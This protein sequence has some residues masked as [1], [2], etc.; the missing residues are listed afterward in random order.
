MAAPVPAA[1]T[2]D[3]VEF[4]R[5]YAEDPRAYR[6]RVRR[7]VWLG[8]GYV[9]A[10]L[11]VILGFLGGG[12]AIFAS[13]ALR[14]TLL[15]EFLRIGV[16]AIAIAGLM[17][18]AVFVR[19]PRP[20]GHYLEGDLKRAVLDF[21]E[22]IRAAT[23]GCRI[24]D[25]VIVSDLN[26]AVQQRPRWGLLGPSTNYLIIGAP[27]FQ[28]MTAEELKAVIAHEFGHLSHAHGRMG[29]TVY[30]LD[31][32][33]RHAASAIEEKAKP[34]IAA[35]TFKFF[36]WFQPRFD[37]VTFAMRRGQE[38]EADSVAAGATSARAIGASLCRLHAVGD[39]WG[40]YW[41]RIWSGSRGEEDNA[42]IR[43]W[44]RLSGEFPDV[45]DPESGA[46]SIQ[47]ALEREA[48]YDDTHPCLRD[49]LAALEVE[50]SPPSLPSSR[51]LD[52]IF[53]PA[54]REALLDRLDAIWCDGSRENWRESHRAYREAEDRLASLSSQRASLDEPGLLQLASLEE[55]LVDADAARSTLAELVERFPESAEARFHQGRLLFEGDFPASERAFV[56]CVERDLE[57][58]PDALRYV[59]HRYEQDGRE[60]D[61]SP[62]HPFV[63][64][65]Q[66]RVERANEE[67]ESVNA[68]DTFV[69]AHLSDEERE[70]LVERLARYPEI[71]ALDLV[72]KEAEQFR[73]HRMFVLGLSVNKLHDNVEVKE[74]KWLDRVSPSISEVLPDPH[75]YFPLFVEKRSPWIATFSGVEGARVYERSVSGM[76]RTWETAKTVYSI[77]FLLLF[78][79]LLGFLAWSW[80]R[81]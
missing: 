73:E 65:Y 51:A 25:V 77:V 37:T 17:V 52:E 20:E 56:A 12:V 57:W 15:D 69:A 53:A 47:A 46:A 34:G 67:R 14:L 68:D 48:T 11:V 44:H 43:P 64:R 9:G 24:D 79:G 26:A 42:R 49:R 59:R 31:H 1:D 50:P 36:N 5:L 3:Y 21:F 29:A 70:G 39:A 55:D 76:K 71:R 18:R 28:L 75:T 38:Y 60:I 8:Y 19:I 33:L 41:S 7:L 74:E 2:R 10:C 61:S 32:A 40:A 27:L 35:W 16:P 6:G 63:E 58:L 30:R 81:S 23:G 54:Q 62:L 78:V 45:F 66:Q 72:E 13:G 22:P 80:L 4:E